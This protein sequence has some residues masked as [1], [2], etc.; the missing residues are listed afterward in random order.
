[1]RKNKIKTKLKNKEIVTIVSG[2][3][4]SEMID[5]LGPIGVDG[6]WLEGEHGSLSWEQIGN[7]SRACDLWGMTSITRVNK[8][9]PGLIMRTL[10][11]G[12][13]GIVVPHVNSRNDAEQVVQAAKYAPVGIRGMYGGRQSYGENSYYHQANDQIL[14]VVL[15]EELKAVKNLKEILTVDNVDVFFVAPSDLAQTMG[16][17][18]NFKHPEVQDMV[19]STLSQIVAAGKN[20]GTLVFDDTVEKYIEAGILFLFTPWNN[21]VAQGA[22]SFLQK[23]HSATK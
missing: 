19:D 6:I 22:T 4:G 20:A 9:D 21:W 12:S 14:V 3:G 11:R 2:D 5:F 16:H 18:D 13:M 7:R 15:I 17:G 1:M 23:V 8:N 10:D